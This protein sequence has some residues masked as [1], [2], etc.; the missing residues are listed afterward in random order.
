MPRQ[1]F[2]KLK[3]LAQYPAHEMASGEIATAESSSSGIQQI[4]FN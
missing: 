4:S 2:D 3:S 1:A